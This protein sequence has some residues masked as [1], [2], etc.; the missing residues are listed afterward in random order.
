MKRLITFT[1][2]RLKKVWFSEQKIIYTV[3]QPIM[4]EKKVCWKM[5]LLL[6]SATRCNRAGAGALMNI[7]N[8]TN[9]DGNNWGTIGNASFFA[10]QGLA[11]VGYAAK[12]S[13]GYTPQYAYQG[14]AKAEAA[15]AKTLNGIAKGT[16]VLGYGATTINIITSG[17]RF[18]VS[19]RSWGDYGQL[20]IASLSFTLSFSGYT[21]PIGVGIGFIDI[22]GGFNGFYNHL[23]AQNQFYDNTGGVILPV[24]GI[25]YYLQLKR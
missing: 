3:A 18:Y 17:I 25:P 1:T 5:L 6:S 13:A 11:A 9:G 7:V 2:I 8:A 23:D 14:M 12:S 21:A 10:G 16:K 22:A 15:A 20:G 24:N 19:D 4:Q